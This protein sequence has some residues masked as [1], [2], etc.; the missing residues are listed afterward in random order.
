MKLIAFSKLQTEY[1]NATIE[2]EASVGNR[3]ADVL[4]RFPEPRHPLGH[5][6]AVEVQHRNNTKNVLA[7]DHDY[8]DDGFSVLWLSKQHYS[9]F[10]VELGDIQ[11]VWPRS[12][13]RMRGYD[14]LSWPVDA[15]ET[16][17]PVEVKIP[18]PDELLTEYE[19]ELR[20][21]FE[22]GKEQRTVVTG[23]HSG[24]PVINQQSAA[25]T[26]IDSTS[27]KPL[28]HIWLSKRHHQTI[29]ALQHIE[30]PTG[31][32]YLK[33]SKGKEG[34]R[35]EFVTV[36]ITANNVDRLT[37][38]HSLLESA[39]DHV[40]TEG[41][42]EDIGICWLTPRKQPMTAWLGLA[43]T[44]WDEY[45]FQLGKKDPQTETKEEL[46]VPFSVVSCGITDLHTFFTAIRNSC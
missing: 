41:E 45:A 38:I 33:L 14:G 28:H 43:S 46:T 32:R 44:P 37:E 34:E 40:S 22:R 19:Q 8:Y 27:W 39:P 18:F 25:G 5:G 4:V 3:R 10:D 7:T 2:L 29:R 36:P 1:P 12:L 30:S 26:T 15:I 24:Q 20:A 13:P 9:G 42:W 17:P 16:N 21:A 31:A 23:E 6:I 11:P 35:P